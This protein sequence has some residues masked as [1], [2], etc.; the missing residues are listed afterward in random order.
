MTNAAIPND[1]KRVSVFESILRVK[2]VSVI[3]PMI[4][5]IILGLCVNPN[6]TNKDNIWFLLRT[7]SFM[8]I[9]AIPV[10]FLLTTK[11]MDLSVGQVVAS[12]GIILALLNVKLGVPMPL[13]LVIVLAY[14]ALIGF[15][16]GVLIVNVGLPSFLTTL[17]MQFVLS[18]ITS[19]ITKGE[20]YRGFPKWFTNIGQVKILNFF[21]VEMV[22]FAVLAV[23]G[24]IILTRTVLGQQ[25][26]LVGT[27]AKTAN[28]CGI[29]QK[30]IQ[31]GAHI[32]TSLTGA[33]A[34]V[35]FCARTAQATSG[36]GGEWDLQLMVAALLGGTSMYGGRTSVIGTVLG[37]I[38][39][40]LLINV[41]LMLGLPADWQYVGMGVS[42][43]IAIL[44]DVYRT[45]SLD[46]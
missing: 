13:A 18:G 22:V 36:T 30:N 41:L 45:R 37:M 32:A 2:E 38:Y 23:V 17:G 4:I 3:L 34:A 40:R 33:V 7:A 16:N 8:G 21:T 31:K 6:F 12:S 20:G 14:G 39:M 1:T 10:G 11:S 35:L 15:V 24:H 29:S 44:F 43:I 28:L 26:L 5:L 42:M 19:F 25:I 46:K 9:I 27:N